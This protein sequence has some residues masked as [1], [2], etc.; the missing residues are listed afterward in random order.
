LIK[1]ARDGGLRVINGLFVPT[2]KN[3]V[4][5]DFYQKNGFELLE[6]SEGCTVWRL[7]VSA[8]R[9]DCP[10]WIDLRLSEVTR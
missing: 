2:E 4:A 9:V 3:L 1:K 8:A 7:D 6:Q 5:R 10:P